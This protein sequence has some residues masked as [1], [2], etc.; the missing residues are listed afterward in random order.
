M[1]IVE[2]RV[3]V[4]IAGR[5]PTSLNI[6]LCDVCSSILTERRRALERVERNEL[7]YVGVLFGSFFH[8]FQ[9]RLIQCTPQNS[10]CISKTMIIHL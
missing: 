5:S 10:Y 1:F 3:V 8:V 6:C 4:S 2:C 7:R 9:A